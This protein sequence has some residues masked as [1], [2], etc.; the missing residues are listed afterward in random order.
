MHSKIK[1][2]LL[3]TLAL[4]PLSCVS[5]PAAPA[6]PVQ[7]AATEAQ[8]YPTPEEAAKALLDAAQSSDPGRLASLFGSRG[9]ELLSSGDEVADKSNREAFVAM[10]RERMSVDRTGED[11]AIL[12][13]GKQD[14]PFPIPLA[15]SGDGWRFDADRG[16]EE[17]INR[18]IGRNELSTLGVINGYLEAQFDYA[19]VDR[20]GDG[21]SEYARKF[22][23]E[24]GKFDG[25][26]W[27]AQPGQPPSP[28]GPLVAEARAEGYALKAAAEKPTPYHGYYYRILTRQGPDAVGGKYD[29]IINGHMIAGFGLVAFPADYGNSGVMTFIVNHQGR[30]Y[31][32][33][34]GPKTAETAAA[35]KEFNP[36]PGWA[37]VQTGE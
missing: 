22:R 13:A 20:D 15:K 12:H 36:G 25:L 6:A 10:A 34:L 33:D 8:R 19:D 32:K 2:V 28:L 26:Y 30:I 9:A 37:P 17:I 35:M 16:R 31:Q 23:S 1:N 4:A 3:T 18:R 14:W 11:R 29:Y 21:M 24:P 27:E 5:A 7:P